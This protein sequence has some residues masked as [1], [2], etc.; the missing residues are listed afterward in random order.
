MLL[1]YIAGL[2]CETKHLSRYSCD[3]KQSRPSSRNRRRR[4]FAEMVNN[5]N[6]TQFLPRRRARSRSIHPCQSCSGLLSYALVLSKL[7]E[8]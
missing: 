4:V 6:E 2:E 1:F 7:G 8:N 5:A 3:S